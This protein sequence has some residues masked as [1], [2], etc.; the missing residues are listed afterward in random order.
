[1]A[2]FLLPALQLLMG[3]RLLPV[4]LSVIVI[5]LSGV[6]TPGPMFAV[7]VAKSYHSPW[8]GVQISLGHAVVEVPIILLIYFGFSHFFQ[9]IVVQIVLSI[10]GGCMLIW[11]GISMFRARKEVVQTGKDLSY[12]GVTAGIIMSISNPFFLLWWATVGIA[13]VAK[14]FEFGIVG[15]PILVV[16]HWSCDLIWLSIVSLVIFR[17]KALWGRQ[18]QSGI[19]IICSLLLLGFGGWFIVSGVQQIM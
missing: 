15:L 19:F 9:N 5:S 7:T 12:N 10:V 4:I 2:L 1:V 18:F 16:T 13:L 11:M 6:M 8:A 14:F 17:T 3:V